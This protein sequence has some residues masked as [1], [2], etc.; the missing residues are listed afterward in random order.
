MSLHNDHASPR[1]LW[2]GLRRRP[3]PHPHAAAARREPQA[4]LALDSGRLDAELDAL[5]SW[6]ALDAFTRAASGCVGV[7]GGDHGG[8]SGGGGGGGGWCTNSWD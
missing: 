6:G 7:G 4:S 2:I 5:P 8:N 3:A 1:L